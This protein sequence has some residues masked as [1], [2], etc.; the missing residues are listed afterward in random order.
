MPSIRREHRKGESVLWRNAAVSCAGGWIA[1]MAIFRYVDPEDKT[2]NYR[3]NLG[4][5]DTRKGWESYVKG[6]SGEPAE[7]FKV[8][9]L[10]IPDDLSVYYSTR[11]WTNFDAKRWLSS[12]IRRTVPEKIFLRE[13]ESRGMQ[14]IRIPLSE[15]KARPRKWV[16]M[17]DQTPQGR[18]R[19]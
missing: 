13:E 11:A 6:L 8:S 2:R 9:S 10:G 7:T 18:T 15:V 3:L 14:R 4:R 1:L 19:A 5:I 17:R 12:K 16:V